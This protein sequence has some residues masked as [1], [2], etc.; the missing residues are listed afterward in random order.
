MEIIQMKRFCSTLSVLLLAMPVA[1]MAQAA[2]KTSPQAG[3]AGTCTGTSKS[4]RTCNRGSDH[5][6]TPPT[7]AGPMDA[8]VTSLGLRTRCR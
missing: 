5:R 7:Y 2:Q 6:R 4:G 8:R 3:Y 1:G